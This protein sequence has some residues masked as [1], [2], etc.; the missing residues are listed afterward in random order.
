MT[1]LSVFFMQ[2]AFG[3]WLRGGGRDRFFPAL[4]YSL[5]AWFATSAMRRKLH[6]ILLLFGTFRRGAGIIELRRRFL[7]RGGLTADNTSYLL[8]A[9]RPNAHFYFFVI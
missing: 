9:A 5:H 3:R 2:C 7:D 8:V 6:I 1:L 4:L